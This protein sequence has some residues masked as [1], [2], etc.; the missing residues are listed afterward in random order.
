[1][2]EPE[3]ERDGDGDQQA[4]VVAVPAFYRVTVETLDCHIEFYY[5]RKKGSRR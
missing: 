2:I 4:A 5:S 3:R 1:M